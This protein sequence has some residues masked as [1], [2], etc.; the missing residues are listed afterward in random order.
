MKK[1]TILVGFEA[2]EETI[3]S[4]SAGA[5]VELKREPTNTAD[6]NAIQVSWMA[7]WWAM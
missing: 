2:T 3:N 6:P 4:M 1:I 5:M 7:L